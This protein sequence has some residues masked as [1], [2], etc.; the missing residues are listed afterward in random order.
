M[1]LFKFYF[2]AFR[3][4]Q[5]FNTTSDD[6]FVVL[7]NNTTHGLKIV[8]E[9]FKFGQKTHSILNIASVL[10]GGSSNL[11]Y[12]YDSHHSVVGLRHVVNGKVWKQKSTKP[13]KNTF[14]Q[15]NSISC[16]NEESILEHEI[17]D[18]EHSL[19][20]LTAMSNFCGKKYSLESVHRLQEKGF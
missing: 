18:V 19:F 11:G 10:H 7:T 20:V 1:Y 13:N 16:V 14:F 4:L 12:L 9:N 17:P 2:P 15:V 8:A 3:I 6:Y 5:Y